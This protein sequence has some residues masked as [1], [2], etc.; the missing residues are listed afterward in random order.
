MYGNQDKFIESCKNKFLTKDQFAKTS[1]CFSTNSKYDYAGDII[2][3][4][5][6]SFKIQ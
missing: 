6:Y 2:D 4:S 3:H 5:T 1:S